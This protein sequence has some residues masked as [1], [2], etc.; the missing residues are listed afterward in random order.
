MMRPSASAFLA[1]SLSALA[2]Q[3]SPAPA[4]LRE[5]LIREVPHVRQK[6]DFCGEACAAMW[7]R[8]LGLPATQD[9]VFNLADIDPLQGRGAY[10]QDLARAL[11]RIGFRLGP[12]WNRVP[13][14]DEAGV[15][16]QFRDLVGDLHRGIP[17]IICMRYSADPKASEH[18][19]LVLGYDA[20][21]DEVLFHEPAEARGAYRR[22]PRARFIRL[23]TLASRDQTWCLIRLKLEGKASDLKLPAAPEG[24][25]PADYAQQV[26]KVREWAPKGFT[27]ALVPPF[28]VAGDGQPDQVT[29]LAQRTVAW[30]VHRLKNAF[31]PKDPAEVQTIWLFKDKASY[32]QHA[33][34]FFRDRPTTPYG[35][36]SPAKK[37]LIMNIATGGGTLVHELVHPLMGANFPACPPWLNEGMGS[38]FEAC[39]DRDGQIVGRVNW[40]L[41]GLQEAI[42]AGRLP[43]FRALMTLADA[44]FYDQDPHQVHYAMARYLC[45]HLQEKGLLKAFYQQFTRDQ[46]QDPSGTLSLAKVLGVTDLDAFQKTWEAWVLTLKQ[47]E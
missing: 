8:K 35:Y 7:L 47:P 19:R 44:P 31:F 11:T 18:F 46:V 24:L 17:S 38:L 39:A 37:A 33:W 6:P 41:A 1:G 36:Y 3:P 20:A 12:V 2:A 14:G 26:M 5:V 42:R 23:W 40:R 16:R 34:T 4:D 28:V 30:A 21:R 25:S 43:T 15:A 32:D 45:Y 29:S 27:L 13:G 22:M 9:A 10:A